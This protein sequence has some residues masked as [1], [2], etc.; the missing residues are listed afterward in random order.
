[1]KML[2]WVDFCCKAIE[3]NEG[4]FIKKCK[5]SC[6][7]WIWV[8]HDTS[9]VSNQLVVK[10]WFITRSDIY[11][12]I[13]SFDKFFEASHVVTL[14]TRPFTLVWA[15][16]DG[17]PYLCNQFGWTNSMDC[18]GWVGWEWTFVLQNCFLPTSHIHLSPEH[19]RSMCSFASELKRMNK[20]HIATMSKPHGMCGKSK[21]E[22]S[23]I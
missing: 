3:A 8:S 20:A 2:E 18:P 12:A 17:F 7:Y 13:F 21:S 16:R 1:M 5:L 23:S 6:K 9:V 14:K 10:N 15:F 22:G 19:F 4:V 11:F